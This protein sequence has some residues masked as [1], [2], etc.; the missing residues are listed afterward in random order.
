MKI[1]GAQA[2]VKCLEEEG[3]SLLFGYPGVAI[4]PFYDSVYSSSIKNVLVRTEQNAGHAANGYARVTGKPAVCVVTSGP[5]ATN[6]ITALATA[7]MDSIPLIAISGQVPSDQLGSDVFQE[8]DITGSAEPFT[9]YSYLVKD[10]KDIPRIFKEAFHIASTGRP[11][12]V[13]IDVPMD[14]QNQLIDFDEYPKEVNIRGYKPN[15]KGHVM[16]IKRVAK[17]IEDAKQ[18]VICVGG[19]IFSSK[20]QDKLREFCEKLSIPVISTMMG[21][22]ALPTEHPLYFGML[23]SSGKSYANKA[24]NESDLLIIIGARVADRAVT[25]PRLVEK[26][27][28]TVHIDIDPAEIGKIMGTNIPIVG[29]AG[30]V[31]DQILQNEIKCD[32]REWISTLNKWK[33][34]MTKIKEDREGYVNPAKFI[35][36]LSEKLD[37]DVIYVADVGQNQLWSANNHIVRNGRFFTTGGMGTMGYSI[38]A[39][40]GAKAA[41]PDRQV[42]AVCGD[43]SF[44]MSFMELATIVQFGIKIKVIIMRNTYLGLVREFQHNKM[45]D[46]FMAVSLEGSPDFGILASAYG[47]PFIR[48][49]DMNEMN[50]SIEKF[51]EEKGSCIMELNIYPFEVTQ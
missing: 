23:G 7:Y 8:V 31:L 10:A 49:K 41:A 44:Q 35:S 6:L 3:I 27:T 19:G 5:G 26:D 47:I 34:Q 51:I 12:P 37:E 39:A 24:L 16:Q 22:G 11:G 43:G 40:M 4:C 2:M 25:N 13:L 17:A 15:V 48:V 38:P 46:R 50:Q 28:V 36:K 42:V 20:A 18:P 29:D 1:T 30:K 14:I 9:K 33:E 32:N 21:I 45:E